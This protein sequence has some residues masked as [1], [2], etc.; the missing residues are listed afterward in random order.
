MERIDRDQITTRGNKTDADLCHVH[1]LARPDKMPAPAAW[2]PRPGLGH[3]SNIGNIGPILIYI[4][5]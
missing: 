2:S 1:R 3:H 5:V 4:M